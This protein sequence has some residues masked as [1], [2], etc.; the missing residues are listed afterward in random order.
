MVFS[1]HTHPSANCY[2]RHGCRCAECK[3]LFQGKRRGQKLDHSRGHPSQYCYRRHGCRCPGCKQIES[4]GR[5]LRQMRGRYRTQPA[6]PLSEGE[7]ARLRRA[8][9]LAPDVGAAPGAYQPQRR[10]DAAAQA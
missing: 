6:G 3:D 2:R 1:P 5:Y 9:G 7:V 10:T 8:V 4:A